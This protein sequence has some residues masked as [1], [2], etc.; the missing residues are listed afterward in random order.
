MILLIMIMHHQPSLISIQN[1]HVQQL[2]KPQ[3]VIKI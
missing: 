3:F 2:A 1:H